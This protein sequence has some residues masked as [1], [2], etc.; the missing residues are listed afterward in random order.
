V[1]DAAGHEGERLDTLGTLQLRLQRCSR[2]SWARICSVCFATRE[3]STASQPST[4]AVSSSS[5]PATASARGTVHSGGS[6]RSVISS[7]VRMR[8]VKSIGRRY[9]S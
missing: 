5:P 6:S 2:S 9:S 7:A 1:G 8:S 4:A 3:R